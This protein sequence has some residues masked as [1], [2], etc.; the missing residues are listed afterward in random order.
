[1][2]TDLQDV[3]LYSLLN[4]SLQKISKKDLVSDESLQYLH[5]QP[6]IMQHR[7]CLHYLVIISFTV[8]IQCNSTVTHTVKNIYENG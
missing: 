8:F 7:S 1:M 2:F 5:I 4:I 6:M 3:I